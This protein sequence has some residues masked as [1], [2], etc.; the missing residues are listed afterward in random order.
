MTTIQSINLAIIKRHNKIKLAAAKLYSRIRRIG[1]Q[2][3]EISDNI[4]SESDSLANPLSNKLPNHI[5]E[6]FLVARSKY[7]NIL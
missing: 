6:A 7:K 5:S 2:L 3:L 4:G 1:S